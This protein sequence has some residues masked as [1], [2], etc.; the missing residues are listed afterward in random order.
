MIA[1]TDTGLCANGFGEW[2]CQKYGGTL[3]G[4]SVPS[5]EILFMPRLME[6]PVYMSKNK[7][8]FRNE[9]YKVAE[10]TGAEDAIIPSAA[11]SSE[12]FGEGFLLPEIWIGTND[13]GVVV[14][15]PGTGK[16]RRY[17]VENGLP[18]NAIR[19]ISSNEDCPKYCDFRDI[20]V[21]T[22]QGL[23]HWDDSKWTVITTGN[24][25]PSNDIRGVASGTPYTAWVVTGG[26]AAY[27]DGKAWKVYTQ[28]NG[29]PGG[30]LTGVL[31]QRDEILFSTRSNGLIVFSVDV[32]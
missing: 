22:D 16:I 18:G 7:V 1:A 9:T 2:E 8:F 21:A 14:I 11:V 13:Y 30:E 3:H 20:W 23:A 31:W 15:Q 12:I 4:Y 19:A 10:I 26:G 28:E 6:E 17:T 27:F 25:L 32:P 24:G 5:E 29:L